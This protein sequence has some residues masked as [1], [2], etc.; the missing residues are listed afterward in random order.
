MLPVYWKWN[1]KAW[2][3]HDILTDWYTSYFC[4][5]VLCVSE[6]NNLLSKALLLDNVPGHPQI[7]NEIRTPLDA[8]VVY[9]HP[10]TSVL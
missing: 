7:L 8:K 1:K 3:T 9:M 5:T 6:E 2:V 4:P 10:N